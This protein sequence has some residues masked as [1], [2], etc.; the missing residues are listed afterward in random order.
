MD[1]SSLED[2][3]DLASSPFPHLEDVEDLDFEFDQMDNRPSDPAADNMMDDATEQGDA[4]EERDSGGDVDFLE[5]DNEEEAAR[6]DPP[7]E[8]AMDEAAPDSH[9]DD[10]EILYEEEDST[11][12][13]NKPDNQNDKYFHDSAPDAE[14][15]FEPDESVRPDPVDGQKTAA[16]NTT[17]TDSADYRTSNSMNA[18]QDT[19]K[20]HVD[21]EQT[22]RDDGDGPALDP[23]VT[24]YQED[25]DVDQRAQPT[26]AELKV[27]ESYEDALDEEEAIS[28]FP[29]DHKI[30]APATPAAVATIQQDTA[31]EV[32]D[33]ARV[34]P[35]DI[36]PVRVVYQGVEYSLFPPTGD[37]STSYFLEDSNLATEPLDVLLKSCREVVGKPE[38]LEHHDELVLDVPTLGLHICEDSK[39]AAQIKLSDIVEVYVSLNRNESREQIE[40]LYCS[41][42]TRVCLSTQFTWLRDQVKEGFAFS[43]IAAQ[44]VDTP[45]EDNED[46]DATP[47]EGQVADEPKDIVEA[48]AGS[49]SGVQP[50][51]EDASYTANSVGLQS[52]THGPFDDLPQT[53]KIVEE[54]KGTDIVYTVEEPQQ[55]AGFVPPYVEGSDTVFDPSAPDPE[56]AHSSYDGEADTEA[57]EVEADADVSEFFQHAIDGPVED[58]EEDAH[59]AAEEQSVL[60][61]MLGEAQVEAQS[62]LADEKQRDNTF[63]NQNQYDADEFLINSEEE[64]DG[65]VVE[66]PE[67][68]AAAETDEALVAATNGNHVNGNKVPIGDNDSPAVPPATPS[69]TSSKRKVS[70]EEEDFVLDLDT[71]EPKRRRPS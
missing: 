18:P 44:H 24:E 56:A 55:E 47:A 60:R 51:S 9:E 7:H 42:S 43:H 3:M 30:D 12:I 67:N 63:D 11:V 59:E 14:D 15:L 26:E 16:A 35:D 39:Y 23:A 6:L 62:L 27:E 61:E 29:E 49:E 22:T 58:E 37:D 31:V 33:N 54:V 64:S 50:I 71:P 36:H 40:P 65:E 38:D 8:F 69:K 10:E 41:L 28:V 66:E 19:G 53:A 34:L 70:D 21:E 5:E 4:M 13:V 17:N 52:D 68:G 32:Q 57:P 25:L 46:T 1:F 45:I 20:P 2:K 48:A